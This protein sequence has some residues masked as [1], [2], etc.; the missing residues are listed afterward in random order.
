M[1]YLCVNRYRKPVEPGHKL[2]VTLRYMATGARDVLSH[3]RNLFG[4][5]DEEVDEDYRG[6]VRL[7]SEMFH[8][9]LQ[10]IAPRITKS[11]K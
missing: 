6:Y 1:C 4:E 3:F 11:S 10:R 5:L 7:D 9:V 2:L 8:E